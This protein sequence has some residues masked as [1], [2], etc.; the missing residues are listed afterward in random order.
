MAFS[1]RAGVVTFADHAV[2]NLK[3]AD[4][5]SKEQLNQIV[6]K[7]ALIGSTTRID[8]GLMMV[9]DE[10]K[11]FKK[12]DFSIQPKLVFLLTD[13]SQTPDYDVTDLSSIGE[14]IRKMGAHVFA[15]GVGSEV[16]N[17]ELLKIAGDSKKVLVKNNF[18]EFNS[19]TFI[20]QVSDLACRTGKILLYTHCI[21]DF[22]LVF[23]V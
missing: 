4:F 13:G 20:Q 21:N 5:K 10:L 1:S 22:V 3:L 14:E 18:N 19:Q 9:R 8:K 16:V 6:D 17:K 2:A 11:Q 7:L 23:T 12:E 15:I